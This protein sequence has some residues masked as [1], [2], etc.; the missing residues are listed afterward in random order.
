[1]CVIVGEINL[2][3]VWAGLLCR[4]VSYNWRQLAVMA[5]W[6]VVRDLFIIVAGLVAK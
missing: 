6:C 5:I 4:L 2:K 1:M 3:V